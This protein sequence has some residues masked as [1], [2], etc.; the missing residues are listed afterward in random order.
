M[1]K[2]EA[3]QRARQQL[4]DPRNYDPGLVAYMLTDFIGRDEPLYDLAWGL[5]HD[6]SCHKNDVIG[7]IELMERPGA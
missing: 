5:G 3:I 7:L 4:A 6:G 1:T 2:A